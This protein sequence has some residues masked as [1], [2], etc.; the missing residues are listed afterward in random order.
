MLEGPKGSSRTNE[1]KRSQRLGLCK[2]RYRLEGTRSKNPSSPSWSMGSPRDAPS[3][4]REW[5]CTAKHLITKTA[6][7][8]IVWIHHDTIQVVAKEIVRLVIPMI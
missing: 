7:V 8:A 5:I 4:T 3:K 6:V 1:A 2:I